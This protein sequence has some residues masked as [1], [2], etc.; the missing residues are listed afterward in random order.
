M[1]KVEARFLGLWP[2]ALSPP[3]GSAPWPLEA[4]R[5][6]TLGRVSHPSCLC[7]DRTLTA[8]WRM[9]SVIEMCPLC[10]L[11]AEGPESAY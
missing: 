10:L 8:F 9:L 5:V 1:G 11:A 4:V 3:E 7:G 6:N 2:L